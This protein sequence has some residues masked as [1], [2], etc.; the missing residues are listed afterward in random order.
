MAGAVR[1]GLE[2]QRAAV[3]QFVKHQDHILEEFTEIESGR[4]NNRIQLQAAIH[5]AKRKQLPPSSPSSTS[6][7]FFFILRY[8]GV[9]IVC[10]DMP[11]A[12]TLTT[13]I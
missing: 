7:A 12:N 13:G 1:P 6:A 5:L 4:K 10:A 2:A 11:K 3:G 8:S 9:D